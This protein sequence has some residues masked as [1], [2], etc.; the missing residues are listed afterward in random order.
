[1]VECFTGGFGPAAL[2]HITLLR[3][4]PEMFDAPEEAAAAFRPLAPYAPEDELRHW[5]R[6]SLM[7]RPDGRWTWRSDPVLRVPGPPGRL[8]PVPEVLR[9]RLARVRCPT[10]LVVGEES[11]QDEA[12]ASAAAANPQARLVR[13]PQAGHWV[14]L[15]NPNGFVEVVGQFLAGE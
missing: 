12:V 8:N 5:M 10:L 1:M 3:S 11:F 2:A 4:L 9:E 13:I 15:D 14:P 7:Q 6:E